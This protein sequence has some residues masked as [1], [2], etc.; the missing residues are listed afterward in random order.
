MRWV[1]SYGDQIT[2][3]NRT[4]IQITAWHQNHT[5]VNLALRFSHCCTCINAAYTINIEKIFVQVAFQDRCAPR[6]DSRFVF[7]HRVNIIRNRNTHHY[8]DIFCPRGKVA[9]G[10]AVIG[11]DLSHILFNRNS[12]CRAGWHIRCY[13]PLSRNTAGNSQR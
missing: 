10:H 1:V 4:R 5:G 6:P 8:G 13:G 3:R 9:K 11:I 2:M 7:G 12:G